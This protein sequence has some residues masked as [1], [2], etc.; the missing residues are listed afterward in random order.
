VSQARTRAP[1]LSEDQLLRYENEGFLAV[2]EPLL[3]LDEIDFVRSRIDHLFERWGDLPRRLAFGSSENGAPPLIAQIHRVTAVDSA[4]AHSA[5]L[6]TCREIA[7]FI[8]GGRHA[9]CRFD[10]AI[11]KY[12]GAGPVKWHQDLAMSTTGI[13]KHSVHFWIPLNNHGGDSGSMVFVRGSH[14]TGLADHRR[15]EPPWY[16]VPKSADLPEGALTV[17]VPL[18][19]G[20]FSIHDPS[21]MH[22][23]EPNGGDAI[24]KAVVF[25]FSSSPWSAA[26]QIG[27]PLAS[28][29]LAHP[30]H[31]S[32]RDDSQVARDR[33]QSARRSAR[34]MVRGFRQQVAGALHTS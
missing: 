12:P 27:R 10:S 24:R 18:S 25:E 5:L 29:L 8:M 4:I 21:T 6:R 34:Q 33:G 13:P 15:S 23:S 32:A 7:G 30:S 26:R 2:T 14:R 19:V 31:L 9:W 17:S 3:P 22:R 28:A 16:V 20:N 1:V 11:Y